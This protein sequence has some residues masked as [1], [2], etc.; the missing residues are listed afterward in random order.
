[1]MS[2]FQP[3]FS[4]FCGGCSCLNSPQGAIIFSVIIGLL[5][6]DV[7]DKEGLEDVGNIVLTIGQM[8]VTAGGL[9]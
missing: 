7:L 6:V 3:G 1:M 8:L 2:C 4:R 5:L 9:C